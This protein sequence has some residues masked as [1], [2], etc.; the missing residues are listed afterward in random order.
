MGRSMKPSIPDPFLFETISSYAMGKK[1]LDIGC[2]NKTY[3]GVSDQTVTLDGW[4]AVNPD[5]LLNLEKDDLPFEENE[6]EC[7]LLL[8]VIEHIE[9]K[10]G[11]EILEQAKK[12]AS[13]RVYVFTPLWWDTNEAHTN[14][15]A[16]WA[17][18]NQLNLHKS[19]WPLEDWQ[20]WT[21]LG[22]VIRDEGK[23]YDYFF[24]YWEQ[25]K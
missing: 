12:I 14:D 4:D 9:R 1:T 19:F 24:G 10:R 23:V 7:V 13:G 2:G 5:I 8:D 6:F 25:S 11:E 3:S 15:P 20:D 17:Y 21:K 22:Y 18:G 16:C